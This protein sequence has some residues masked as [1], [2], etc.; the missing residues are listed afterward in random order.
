MHFKIFKK[1]ELVYVHLSGEPN[2]HDIIALNAAMMTN[3]YFK[4][5][6]R[7]FV[8]GRDVR[9]RLTSQQMPEIHKEVSDITPITGPWAHLSDDPRYIA[10][11]M[12]YIQASAHQHPCRIVYSLKEAEDFLGI[13]NISYYLDLPSKQEE[14]HTQYFPYSHQ[15]N[16]VKQA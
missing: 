3:P 5:H 8:D 9:V 1:I 15:S 4:P 6:F 11:T 12:E 2:Q 7:G 16:K 14:V 13:E 10:L